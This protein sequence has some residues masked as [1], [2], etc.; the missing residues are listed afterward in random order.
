MT[1]Y[2][3]LAEL[4]GVLSTNLPNAKQTVNHIQKTEI[5]LSRAESIQKA[6]KIIDDHLEFLIYKRICKVNTLKYFN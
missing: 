4:H 1:A 6:Y 2:K 3:W 5:A